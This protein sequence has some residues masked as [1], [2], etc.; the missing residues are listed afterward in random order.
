MLLSPAL[1]DEKERMRIAELVAHQ[2][3]AFED[4]AWS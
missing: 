3:E 2:D 1:I 4:I